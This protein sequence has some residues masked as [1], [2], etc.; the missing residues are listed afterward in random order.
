[1][2]FFS[3]S[4]INDWAVLRY[5]NLNIFPKK[6]TKKGFKISS[7]SLSKMSEVQLDGI[8]LKFQNN[9]GN[10]M[11]FGCNL[12]K[13]ERKGKEICLFFNVYYRQCL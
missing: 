4:Q 13:V 9:L 8:N 11:M 7:V 5:L 10:P 1:M 12:E 3:T 2:H 6:V